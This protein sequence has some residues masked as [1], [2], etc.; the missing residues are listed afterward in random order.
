MLLRRLWHNA[1]L[2]S[3]QLNYLDKLHLDFFFCFVFI[4]FSDAIL[5]AKRHISAFSKIREK[6][7]KIPMPVFGLTV[8]T[9]ALNRGVS[10][11]VQYSGEH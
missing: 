7:T 5:E 1:F 3:K 9:A 10:S 4:C 8:S 2:F 11:S 6:S